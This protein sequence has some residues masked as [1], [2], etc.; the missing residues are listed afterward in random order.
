[1]SEDYSAYKIVEAERYE[2]EG[3]VAQE[4]LNALPWLRNPQA[5]NC[6]LCV[7]HRACRILI[8]VCGP[9]GDINRKT[10]LWE[11]FKSMLART[12]QQQ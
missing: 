9:A 3:E 12:K 11:P 6:N 4:V 2:V 7:I 8:E 5:C 10:G 1:M